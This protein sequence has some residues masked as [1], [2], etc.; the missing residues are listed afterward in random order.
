M[1]HNIRRQVTAVFI[2]F[3]SALLFLSLIIST[4]F[5][6]EYYVKNKEAK[7][8]DAYRAI[9]KAASADT[10]TAESTIELLNQKVEVSNLSFV[11][12]PQNAKEAGLSATPNE[13]KRKELL[14]QLSGYLMGINQQT[15]ELL[16]KT[17]QYEIHKAEDAVNADEYLEMWGTL[18]DGSS[19]ILRTPLES[20]NQNVL[21]SIR[22]FTYIMLILLLLASV[23]VWL[24]SRRLTD[25]IMELARISSRMADLDFEAEYTSGGNNEIGILG[26]NF[27][28]MSKRLES[29]I[30]E[31]K[32]ANYELQKDIEQKEKTEQMRTEFVGN[33]SHELKTPIAL[34]QGYAEG[35]K[36]GISDDPQSREFYCDVIIDE[37]NK[38][39]QLVKNLLTLNQM[40]LGKDEI[41]YSRFNIIELIQGIVESSEIVIRQKEITVQFSQTEP[42][43]V[44]ADEFKAEQV[45]RNYFSNA[46]NHASGEKIVD[47][48]AE[49]RENGRTRVSVFNTGRQIADEDIERIWDKFY[50]IDKAHTREYGGN[51]IGLSIVKAI[52]EAF[53]CD[54]GVNNYQNGVVFWFELE[55]E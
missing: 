36:D 52:M 22:F 14:L 54:Y 27:N 31:L 33:V 16:V 18:S 49:H 2:T 3:V 25:P 6:G 4:L 23:V 29:A 48:R 11:V 42:M 46:L 35:L 50:K 7:L 43:Y 37:A 24:I 13:Q 26:E 15:G 53:R 34:I 32:N 9:D 40:E 5:L 55:E 30:S 28:R 47:I 19:F 20:I 10:L 1:K 39:N 21:L 45:I 12:L 44:W 51:G 8:V 38:M 41:S 17:Q